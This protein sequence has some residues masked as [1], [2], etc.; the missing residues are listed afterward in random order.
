MFYLGVGVG[1]A[2]AARRKG[3]EEDVVVHRRSFFVVL[4]EESNA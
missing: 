3:V 2:H 1:V 4:N